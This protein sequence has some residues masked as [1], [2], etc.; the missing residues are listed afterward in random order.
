MTKADII[1]KIAE[2]TGLQKKDVS[3]VVESFMENIKDSLLSNKENVYLRGFGSFI[4]KHRAAKTA[5]NE[6]WRT[7]PAKLQACKVLC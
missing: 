3:V 5:R 2:S 1:N 7:R 4:I 6:N